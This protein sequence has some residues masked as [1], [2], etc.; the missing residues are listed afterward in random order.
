M[1]QLFAEGI[2]LGKV[3]LCNMASLRENPAKSLI[4]SGLHVKSH[5]QLKGAKGI[6]LI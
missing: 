3:M 2:K 5:N 1:D 6:R 4:F